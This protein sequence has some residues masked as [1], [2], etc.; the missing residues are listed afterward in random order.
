VWFL[1]ELL[2]TAKV[3]V[4]VSVV[5]WPSNQ[6]VAKTN[7][8][9]LAL[10]MDMAVKPMTRADKHVLKIGAQTSGVLWTPTLASSKPV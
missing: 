8:R 2:G 5:G 10:T 3:D 9:T 6:Q 4:N 1:F 7:M